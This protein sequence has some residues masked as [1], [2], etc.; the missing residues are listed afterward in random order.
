[1]VNAPHHLAAQQAGRDVR[2]AIEVGEGAVLPVPTHDHALDYR[3]VAAALASRAPK[4]M[5]SP[6]TT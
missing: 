5:A 2:S 6:P 4:P 1:M 3:L